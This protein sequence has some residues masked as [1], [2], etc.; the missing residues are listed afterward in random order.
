MLNTALDFYEK[1]FEIIGGKKIMSPS[2]SVNHSL[3]TMRVG[4][5]I[6]RRLIPT[7]KGYAL[8]EVD[9][10][11]PDG[12]LFKPDLVIISFENRKIMMNRR[13]IVQG[14][15]D[16]T[17]EILSRSTMKRDT[18]VKKNIY[19][20]NGVKEYWIIDPYRK[21]VQVFTLQDGKYNEG[22]EYVYFDDEEWEELTED[23]KINFP[24]EIT[25]SIFEDLNVKL[26][27]IFGWC[28]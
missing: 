7:N 1:N 22:D 28:I 9:V 21:S 5:A 27:D 17:V 16:M 11:F 23:E 3:V 4:E 15:P 13:N 14:V 8:P 24:Q 25:V 6:S 12:N 10:H 2:P 26:S 20:K 18:T 19:E